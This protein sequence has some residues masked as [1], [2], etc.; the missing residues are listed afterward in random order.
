MATKVDGSKVRLFATKA[1]ALD[2]AR[3]IGWPVKCVAPVET[4]FQLGFALSTG[5]D[6]DPI[7]GMFLSRERFGQLWRDRNGSNG[8]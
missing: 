1:Q 2:A 4:R 7:G 3:S 8:G 5:I 6:V